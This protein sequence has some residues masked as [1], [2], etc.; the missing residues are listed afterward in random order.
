MQIEEKMT[1]CDNKRETIPKTNVY[2][3]FRSR[4]LYDIIVLVSIIAYL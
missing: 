3:L 4:H 1:Y 2:R